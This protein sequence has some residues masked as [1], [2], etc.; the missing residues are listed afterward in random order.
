MTTPSLLSAVKPTVDEFLA[1]HFDFIVIGGGTAGLAVAARLAENPTLT[2]G[3]LEAG[4][5]AFDEDDVNIPGR[6]GRSLGGPHDWK[7]ETV[8]QKGLGGRTLPWP[9]GK[10]LGGSSSALN[11]MTWNRGN[12]E[13]Y[14][15]WEE[16]GNKGWGWNDLLHIETNK[17]PLSGSNVGVWTAIC[18]VD[19]GTGAR[20]Y[21][22]RYVSSNPP[23]SNLHILTGALVQEIILARRESHEDWVATGVRFVHHECEFSVSVSREVILSA[24]EFDPSLP[25]PDD[26]K[27]NPQAAEDA[28]DEYQKH[29][30]GPLT[31]LPCSMS[32]SLSHFTPEQSSII[33]RRFT[34][35]TKLG[36]IEYIF[37]L[38]NWRSIH[39]RPSSSANSSSAS[40]PVIDPKYYDSSHGEL[41]LD[42][43][44]QGARFA[45]EMCKAKPL[46]DIVH[47][48]WAVENTV[49]DWHPVGTCA[50]GGNAG[51]EAGV[52]DERL[53]VYGVKGLRVVDAS[54]M[55][56][57]ISAHFAGD[58]LD[59]RG[60]GFQTHR[61]E[62]HD[63][64]H[65]IGARLHLGHTMLPGSNS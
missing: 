40:R 10:I 43:M 20:S 7:F 15:A 38:G 21:A 32:E 54:I 6:Y 19:P 45:A 24:G 17:A 11:F 60:F 8:G 51:K 61:L 46:A 48:L 12:R 30:T 35:E 39:I 9:R 1:H 57:Q 47:Q 14:D 5:A 65:I 34:G 31:I 2:I 64:P 4:A 36:Q 58:G 27:S 16:L 63:S 44:V 49:T 50:M 18:T 3:V 29:R 56:L 26:L 59:A 13:D 22:P 41:D 53:R 42:I 23:R 52:V 28:K 37:D 33:T 55:P 25:N 62:A